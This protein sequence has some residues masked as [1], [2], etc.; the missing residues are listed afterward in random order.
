MRIQVNTLKYNVTTLLAPVK[1]A[2]ENFITEFPPHVFHSIFTVWDE[3][4][5]EI[6]TPRNYLSATG[7]AAP[8][9][10]QQ[11]LPI[12][13]TIVQHLTFAI[14]QVVLG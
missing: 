10:F 6:Y 2:I 1:V 7:E 13:P 12:Y 4:Y 14:A 8:L 3:V 9:N 5:L 11:L